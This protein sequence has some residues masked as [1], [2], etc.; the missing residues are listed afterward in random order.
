MKLVVPQL[1]IIN[2]LCFYAAA[3]YIYDN[4]SLSCAKNEKC[5][6]QNFGISLTVHLSI[7]LANDQLDAQIFSYI[8]YSPLHLHV[9]SNILLIL[10]R[11]NCINT[12]SGIVTVS[13]CPV[14][15]LRTC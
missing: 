15:R 3:K 6:R 12:A 1:V 5:L 10:R 14:H 11:S 7:T 13:D 4:V 2:P 8:Y 9:S